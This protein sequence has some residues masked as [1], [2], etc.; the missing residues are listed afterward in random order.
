MVLIL[1]WYSDAGKTN[2]WDTWEV[3]IELLR[4]RIGGTQ[5]HSTFLLDQEL[6]SYRH[7]AP[8]GAV[9]R[10][11]AFGVHLASMKEHP[12]L[13]TGAL[14]GAV[15]AIG[16]AF[17]YI[18]SPRTDVISPMDEE[19]IEEETQAPAD[20]VNEQDGA[21]VTGEKGLRVARAG[22]TV[23]IDGPAEVMEKINSCVYSVGWFGPGGNGLMV[24][25]GDG[26]TSPEFEGATEG[27]SCTDAARTHTFAKA[28][29]YT[30]VVTLWHPGPADEPITDWEDSVTVTLE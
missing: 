6:F 12:L 29:S 17:I 23:T 9:V 21:T 20:V 16:L 24:E 15:I 3:S 28:G 30:I 14:V 5:E 11:G 7:T 1:K 8:L 22:R 2:R 26:S 10:L 18:S 4:S 13:T 19:V 27:T 25:W